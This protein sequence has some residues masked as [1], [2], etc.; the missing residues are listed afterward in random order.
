[1]SYQ[2]GH[3]RADIHHLR[4]NRFTGLEPELLDTSIASFKRAQLP[5]LMERPGFRTIFFGKNLQRGV[6]AALT[7]WDS[8]RALRLS[9][10]HE[11]ATRTRALGV[12]GGELGAG[13][14]DRYEIVFEHDREPH[15]EPTVARVAHW[16]GVWPS[17][18]SDAMAVWTGDQLPLLEDL[19]GYCGIVAGANYLLG[20]TVSVSLWTS[21]LALAASRGWERAARA[22]VE[23][24][25]LTPRAVLA[26]TYEVVLA[27]R[28]R[29][30]EPVPAWTRDEHARAL[31]LRAAA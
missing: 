25:G 2:A 11:T 31:E 15:G 9:E 18:I 29:Q 19:D 5:K 12:A 13:M 30:L 10:P 16:N 17:R 23:S 26:D 24:G 4:L 20:N 6:A 3:Q 27:P 28:L 22:S 8:E 7:F 1:M 14:V 21:E